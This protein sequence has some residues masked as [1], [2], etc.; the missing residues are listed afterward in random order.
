VVYSNISVAVLGAGH[1]GLALAG[2]LALRGHLVAL[3]NR[4]PERVAAVAERR[5]IMLASPNSLAG[6]APIA[7][8]TSDMAAALAG[9]RVIFVAVP[10][11]AHAA[12]ARECALHLRDGQTVLLLPGRTGG[13]LEFR[14]VLREAGC[15]ARI[16][17]GEANTFPF[18]AR[19]VAPA[20][21]VLYGAKTEVLAAALPANQTP[22]LLAACRPYLPMLC[23][24]RSVLHT[25]FANLGAILHPVITLLNAQRIEAGESFD[26]YCQGVTPA[27]ADTLAAADAER[28]QVAQAYRVPAFSLRDWIARA[29]DHHAETLL[30]AVGGNPSYAGIKAPA[31]LRHRY[32]LEDVPTGLIPLLH[33]GRAA[34]LV[35]PVLT[36]LVQQ[37]RIRLGKSLWQQERSLDRLGLDGLGAGDIHAYIE[38]GRTPASAKVARVYSPVRRIR[39]GLELI[40]QV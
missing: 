1:G 29:Y 32:L 7:L 40:P 16:V 26:F 11:C 2:Y 39:S 13:A 9:A 37:A 23:P 8:A 12:V 18:A 14:R 3:W 30:Q 24:A 19:C 34:D 10:A 33:L 4:S 28:L 25:G 17:L 15:R 5:G 38:R 35:L 27:V 21:A 31:T 22:N 20:S 6:H 36:G